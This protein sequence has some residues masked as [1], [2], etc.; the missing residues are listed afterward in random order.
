MRPALVFR[1]ATLAS[2]AG[3]W[4]SAGGGTSRCTK[5]ATA[6][7]CGTIG[8]C[9]WSCCTGGRVNSRLRIQAKHFATNGNIATFPTNKRQS[10]DPKN[11]RGSFRG[12]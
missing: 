11:D 6:G 2:L 1:W 5:P 12:R 9:V 4:N 8:R 7:S 10:T 3:K